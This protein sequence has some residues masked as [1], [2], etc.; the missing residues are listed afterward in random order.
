LDKLLNKFAGF[1]ARDLENKSYDYLILNV[2]NKEEI[3]KLLNFIIFNELKI[4]LCFFINDRFRKKLLYIQISSVKEN[5]SKMTDSLKKIHNYWRIN[6]EKDVSF[7]KASKHSVFFDGKNFFIKSLSLGM[8][9]KSI[10]IKKVNIEDYQVLISFG[11]KLLSFNRAI[12]EDE[13]N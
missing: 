10:S 6:F 1:V 12:L 13:F 8:E 2:D 3:E 11:D 4:D 9:K 5:K 7:K